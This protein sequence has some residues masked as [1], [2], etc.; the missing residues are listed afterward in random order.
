MLRILK[1]TAPDISNGLGIRVTIWVSGC[2]NHCKGCHNKWT[3]EYNQGKGIADWSD[4]IKYWLSKDY[5]SGVT[6]SGGD[7]LCQSII[8]L[9]QLQYFLL[10]LKTEFPN[11]NIWLYTGLTYED[12][13]DDQLK[14]LSSVD[15]LVDGKYIE[16]L[17]DVKLAFRGSSNQRIIDLKNSKVLNLD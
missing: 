14:V 3:W 12:L 1:V 13:N 4:E 7:P 15:V 17:R 5:I 2:T 11:K 16:E 9:K 8:D 10:E 6:I